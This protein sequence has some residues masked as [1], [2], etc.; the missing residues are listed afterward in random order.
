MVGQAAYVVNAGLGYTHPSSD[1]SATLLYNVVG[2][3]IAEAGV[4]PMPDSY[5]QAR[6]V[7]DAALRLPLWAGVSLKVDAKNLLDAPYRTLQGTLVR[8]EYRTGRSF[9]VGL[10]WRPTP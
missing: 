10:S 7:L 5:E 9:S 4:Y 6:H 8:S 3:R 2:R 1:M